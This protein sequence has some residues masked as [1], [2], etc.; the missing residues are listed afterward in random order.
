MSRAHGDRPSTVGNN[1]EPF[2]MR[3]RNERERPVIDRQQATDP[4]ALLFS[5]LVTLLDTTVVTDQLC[6]MLQ[7]VKRFAIISTA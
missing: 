2:V 4:Q 7:Q 6:D 5:I 3:E 1:A